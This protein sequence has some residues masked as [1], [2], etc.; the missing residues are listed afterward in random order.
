MSPL[1]LVQIPVILIHL[2]AVILMLRFN[3]RAFT[4]FKREKVFWFLVILQAPLHQYISD[5][6]LT[7]HI[8]EIEAVCVTGTVVKN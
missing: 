3:G 1:W 6:S 4:H 5:L 7:S 2:V 8:D